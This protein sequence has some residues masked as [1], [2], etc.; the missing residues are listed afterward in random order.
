MAIEKHENKP[1]RQRPPISA[2]LVIGALAAFG[3]ITLVQWLLVSVIGLVKV[4][5]AIVVLVGLAGWV[6]ST[7]ANR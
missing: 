1:R 6:V 4:A 5:L 3:A 7:K 2:V